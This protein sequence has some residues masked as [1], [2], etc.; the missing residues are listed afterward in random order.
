M[1]PAAFTV[2]V[3]LGTLAAL[4][5]VKKSATVPVP[6]IVIVAGVL[7]DSANVPGCVACI[8]NVEPTVKL[9][10][11][12]KPVIMVSPIAIFSK[13]SKLKLSFGVVS[14]NSELAMA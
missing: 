14:R 5:A 8:V 6:P 12:V 3:T 1:L 11:V 10:G 7:G 13:I 2:Q 9:V 4:T